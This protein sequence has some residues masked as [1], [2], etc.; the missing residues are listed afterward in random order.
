MDP[1]RRVILASIRDDTAELEELVRSLGYVVA[2]RVIQHRSR[3]APD[4]FLG[5]GKL[6]E[7]REIVMG[8]APPIVSNGRPL[9]VVDA[10]LKP[11]QLFGIEDV[12]GAEVWDRI[13]IILEIF[14]QKAQVKEARLQVELARL[15]Y[16]LPF[17]HEALHRTLTGEHPGFMGGGE[18]PMRTYETHLKR[19]TKKILSELE[20]VKTERA[21]RR[22]GRRR[23]GFQLVAITGYTNSGKSSLLNTLCGSEAYVEDLYFSTLQTTTRR[24]QERW[25]PSPGA[26]LLFTDTVGFIRDLPPWLV[27]AFSSTL[28]EV[29][30]SDVV[31]L[32]VDAS[33]EPALVKSKLETAW[34]L[35][36]E[37]HAPKRRI[38]LLNKSDLL[39]TSSRND[40]H[41][42][43]LLTT[44]YPHVPFLWTSTKTDEGLRQFI[45]VVLGEVLPTHTV[46]LALDP[47]RSRHVSFESWLRDN[48]EILEEHSNP[49]ERVFV[50]RCNAEQ[51]VQVQRHVKGSQVT[52]EELPSSG[53]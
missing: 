29:V 19:R 21:Q 17:V 52:L 13:R 50:V 18:L 42:T 10:A 31:V 6:L 8:G 37:L 5:Q 47:L 32:V 2:G 4:T 45:Q 36:D 30:G 39:Q 15:R 12:V 40:L 43:L 25:V 34:T 49:R 23:S 41:N 38:V 51:F 44:Y 1:A 14:Q 53:N 26:N 3:P 33:E 24:L 9:V 27:D 22:Q 48:T 20:N 11:P 46:R 28:E 35:L 7:I 16:E